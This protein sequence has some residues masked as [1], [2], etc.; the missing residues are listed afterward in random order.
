MD[1]KKGRIDG[2]GVSFKKCARK[3]PQTAPLDPPLTRKKFRWLWLERL[4]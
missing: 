1:T 3:L 2:K 4:V